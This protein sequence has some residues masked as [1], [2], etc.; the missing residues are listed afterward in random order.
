[1]MRADTRKR[2]LALIGYGLLG[3]CGSFDEGVVA[4]GDGGQASSSI[5]AGDTEGITS[6]TAPATTTGSFERGSTGD[7]TTDT[8]EDSTGSNADLPPFPEACY[9][10]QATVDAT[11]AMSPDGPL[12]LTE[13]WLFGDACNGPLHVILVQPASKELGPAVEVDIAIGPSPWDTEYPLEGIV[14]AEV[15]WG[16]GSGTV[17]LLEP[18][19]PHETGIADPD[20]RVVGQIEIHDQGWDL[21]VFVDAYYCGYGDCYCPCE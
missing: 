14:P 4:S 20:V 8:G 18:L 17:E 7:D 2:W 12:E 16:H 19:H 13:A 6:T 9:E 10:P 15:T 11:L 3:A 21:S 5:S 1:M